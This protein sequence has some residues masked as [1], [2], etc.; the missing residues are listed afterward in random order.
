METNNN[1]SQVSPAQ[2]AQENS[3][4]EALSPS[5]QKQGDPILDD[6]FKN[7]SPIVVPG[8]DLRR[9]LLARQMDEKEMIYQEIARNSQ[10]MDGFLT[11]YKAKEG[12]L[13]LE[14]KPDQLNKPLLMTT[15]LNGGIGSHDLLSGMPLDS[16]ILEFRRV[17]NT[18]QVVRK[19]PSF[20]GGSSGPSSRAVKEDFSESVLASLEILATNADQ[21]SVM[22]ETSPLFLLDPPN[23]A[24]GLS[25][26]FQ[27]KYIPDPQ[28]SSYGKVSS[29][30]ANSEIDTQLNYVP[31]NLMLPQNPFVVDGSKTI[32]DLRNITLKVHHSLSKLPEGNYTP[33]GADDRVGY[34]ETGV[35]DFSSTDKESSM[36]RYIH[37][38]NLKNGPVTFWIEN[39][40]P[41]EYRKAIE[42]GVLEWNKAFEKIGIR[43]AL[44]V[45]VQP[46]NPDWEAGD[47][48]YN[49]IRWINSSESGFAGFGPSQV[50]PRT[51]EIYNATVVLEGEAIRSIKSHGTTVD[52]MKNGANSQPENL[53]T[54][55]LAKHMDHACEF[56]SLAA[57]EASTGALAIALGD[58]PQ[59]TDKAHPKRPETPADFV[60]AYIKDVV[61]HEIG[62]CLGLRHN[63]HGSTM[64]SMEELQD[65]KVTKE[66][67]LSSSIMDYTPVNILAVEKKDAEFFSSTIGPYDYWAIDYGYRPVNA[68]DTKG[69]KEELGKIA[70]QASRPEL[71]YGTDEDARGPFSVDPT[72]DIFDLSRDPLGFSVKRLDFYK[73]LWKQIDEKLPFENEG[74]AGV[75]AAFQDALKRYLDTL[76]TPLRFVGGEYTTRAHEGDQTQRVP[77]TPVEK[78]KQMEALNVLDKYLFNSQAFSFSPEFLSKL[79][80]ERQMNNFTSLK[81]Y[82]QPLDFPL[83]QIITSA[84]DKALDGLLNPIRLNR[85][86][87]NEKKVADK[88]KTLTMEEM[89]QWL[90]DTVWSELASGQE[91]TDTRR[92]LQ[93]SHLERLVELA[94][95]PEPAALLY[96]RSPISLGIIPLADVPADAQTLAHY[97]LKELQQELTQ[98]LSKNQKQ[99]GLQTRAHLEFC[100]DTINKVLDPAYNAPEAGFSFFGRNRETARPA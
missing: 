21:K 63:F 9:M 7:Q 30:P 58:S 62:H 33:R 79:A 68:K 70:S 59:K 74:Y 26:T 76:S 3:R 19:N 44:Q 14:L 54:P 66:K 87:D 73:K 94:D 17:D 51:G 12:G 92:A 64:L 80:P 67:G 24:E 47:V 71:A 45:K 46:D 37:R 5:T 95:H 65:P 35:K 52:L 27:T 99:L 41:V 57:Q 11:F 72:V 6:F 38:W 48:R 91:V 1:I 23:L 53:L 29:H 85:L 25:Q 32:P 2:S 31:F 78:S 82:F 43:N 61:I 40:T 8:K 97:Q 36:V 16:F 50:D 28:K 93:K 13:L 55:L 10:K 18:I 90:K 34:F 86:Q 83:L 96:Q 20:E 56:S 98:A 88:S 84:Q 89:F 4:K 100:L 81:S 49:V 69:E 42:E 22:V 15:T 75:R 39:T 60:N 77:F